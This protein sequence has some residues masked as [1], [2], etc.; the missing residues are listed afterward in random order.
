MKGKAHWHI[1][2]G[3]LL[4]VVTAVVFRELS[5]RLPEGSEGY[6]FIAGAVAACKFLGEIFMRALQMLIVPLIVTSVVAG[7]A[8]LHGMEGFGR[9][10]GKTVGFYALTSFLAIVV[11][12]ALV[13]VVKPGIEDGRGSVV[14]KQ[15][16][17]EAA[18]NASEADKAKIAAAQGRK[19]SDVW[20]IF[21]RMFPKNIFSAAS[22]NGQ[23]LGLIVF[24]ILFA[25]AMTRLPLNEITTLRE[26]FQSLND[27]MIV[28]TRWVMLVAPIGVYALVVPVVYGTGIELFQKLGLYFV[29]V[30]AALA[31]HFFITLPLILS[32]MGKVSPLAH[33][34]AMRTAL[35][36]A[37]ST[38]SS[39]AT[40]PVTMRCVQDNAGVTKK[41]ASF[42]LPLGA[43]VNMDG[44]ALY[45]CVAVIFV[46]QV[47]GFEMGLGAQ[48][49]VVVAALL[50]SIGVAG[51]PSASL[52]AILL[53][54]K[55]SG[56]PHATEAAFLLLAI[57]RPLD[58]CR[59]AVNVFGDSCAAVVIG[60]S[61]GEEGILE[62]EGPTSKVEG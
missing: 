8:S 49:M 44:T 47:V 30:L 40:L 55:N 19:S 59:T 53:I 16:F 38:S 39:S 41:T 17:E 58:M 10:G 22:D 61:E 52:V 27:V 6:K 35:L 3:L 24:S 46:S 51:I 20:D 37:F 13:N 21:K 32:V 42:T 7:I 14:I 23:M 48:F 43:T 18:T 29:T 2:A 12:L 62:V 26:V 34:K 33:F 45:E 57:D 15:A 60:K 28:I 4:A 36:T 9:L 1:L 54:M 5:G 50:T 31:V 11:G 25:L 56:I